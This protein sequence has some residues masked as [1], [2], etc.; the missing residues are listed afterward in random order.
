MVTNTNT[1]TDVKEKTVEELRA[2][3][4]GLVDLP[5]DFERPTTKPAL[6]VDI[7]KPV[8]SPRPTVQGATKKK[9]DSPQTPIVEPTSPVV[10]A[11]KIV[12]EP[13]KIETKKTKLKSFE[14]M[15]DAQLE[16][17]S[18]LRRKEIYS[19]LFNALKS[20]TQ[21]EVVHTESVAVKDY[22]EVIQ[23]IDMKL[24]DTNIIDSDKSSLLRLKRELQGQPFTQEDQ[25]LFNIPKKVDAAVKP[26]SK[27]FKLLGIV[28]VAV[29]VGTAVAIWIFLLTH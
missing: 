29:L 28:G 21:K 10:E 9:E 6:T 25:A 13:V 17:E 12:E 22:S 16:E 19:N 15:I 23:K 1:N 20:S 27:L 14:E 7:P 2:E 5:S 11:P 4:D 24:L 26:K 18:D 3:L 8:T